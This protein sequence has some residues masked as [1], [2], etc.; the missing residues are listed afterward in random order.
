MLRLSRAWAAM[1]PSSLERHKVAS[2]PRALHWRNI[3]VE[4]NRTPRET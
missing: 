2:G 3:I 1:F 4:P